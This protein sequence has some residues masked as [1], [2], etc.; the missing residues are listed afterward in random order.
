MQRGHRVTP[1]KTSKPVTPKK[2]IQKRARTTP[3]KYDILSDS[4]S[5][6]TLS[7]DSDYEPESASEEDDDPNFPKHLA[8]MGERVI[9]PVHANYKTNTDSNKWFKKDGKVI[10]LDEEGIKSIEDMAITM[11][12]AEWC[13]H[14][15]HMKP[16]FEIVAETSPIQCYAVDCESHPKLSNTYHIEGFPTIMALKKGLVPPFMVKDDSYIYPGGPNKESLLKWIN[17]SKTKLNH[18]PTRTSKPISSDIKSSH[19]KGIKQFMGLEVGELFK[20]SKVHELDPES[21]DKMKENKPFLI[22][23]FAPWCGHCIHAKDMYKAL[24]EKTDVYALNADEYGE[25]AEKYGVSGFPTFG[26]ISN[27]KLQKYSGP[28]TEDGLMEFSK[29][30]KT[31]IVPLSTNHVI[32]ITSLDDL[33]KMDHVIAMFYAPWCS[34]CTHFKPTFSEL[35]NKHAISFAMVNCDELPEAKSEFG[36]RGFPT[37]H[38]LGMGKILS[39]FLDSPRTE[40][41]VSN[42]IKHA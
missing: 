3:K 41:T 33:R 37:I 11:F 15:Q 18:E 8:D 19:L 28:R 12:F 6:A 31:E 7:D 4:D 24:A 39:T 27:G 9:I 21:L 20:G 34:H 2:V 1:K 29:T 40:E 30:F 32:N 5:D 23:F 14:C 16:V 10:E 25:T 35:A 13:P 42:W 36:I 26:I 38:K 17:E 22:M